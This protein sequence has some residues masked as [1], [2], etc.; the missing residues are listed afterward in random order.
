[1]I[2]T[3]QAEKKQGTRNKKKKREAYEKKQ[4]VLKHNE[5][6]NSTTSD[7]SSSSNDEGS[8]HDSNKREWLVGNQQNIHGR[9][10]YKQQQVQAELGKIQDGVRRMLE[11]YVMKEIFPIMKFAHRKC[12]GN[13][14]IQAEK[15]QGTTENRRRDIPDDD[16][17]R[18]FSGKVSTVF[19]NLRHSTQTNSRTKYLSK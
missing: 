2:I 14:L 16:F 7:A 10:V 11:D 13:I 6:R 4:R 1:M 8:H 9:K 17:I 19:S 5:R 12:L 3:N 18:A 15:M